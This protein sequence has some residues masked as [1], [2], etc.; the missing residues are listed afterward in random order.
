VPSA[1]FEQKA[2]G[3]CTGLCALKETQPAD[4]LREK[5]RRCDPLGKYRFLLRRFAQR[6]LFLDCFNV[7]EFLRKVQIMCVN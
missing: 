2:D 1:L 5:L 3:E 4:Y 6:K 7:N